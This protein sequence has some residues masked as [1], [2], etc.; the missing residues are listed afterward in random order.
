M[1]TLF[2]VACLPSSAQADLAA[3][4]TAAFAPFEQQVGHPDA[5]D[6]IARW[7]FEGGSTGMGFYHR[8]GA[9]LDSR[10]VHDV[11]WD[12]TPLPSLP[13]LCA[14]GPRHLL[15]LDRGARLAADDTGRAWDRWNR[16][17]P[18]HPPA[19]PHLVFTHA[20]LPLTV[21]SGP[22][23]EYLDQ[24]LIRAFLECD[25]GAMAASFANLPLIDPVVELSFPRADVVG[26]A[27]RR[28]QPFAHL[29]TADGWLIWPGQ[30]PVHY[31]FDGTGCPHE[32]APAVTT[33]SD[34]GAYLA[35]QPDEA[36]ILRLR[37]RI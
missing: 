1:G 36:L 7:T 30:T 22:N 34:L 26:R 17:V 35:D 27:V 37:C 15:D 20:G 32:T 19:R 16:L 33:F 14:G 29:L 24:P 8:P 12:G 25:D 11:A 13:D 6:L 28:A 10:L 23:L 31:D 18:L 21:Y 4:L 5:R 9:A 3:A 2:V